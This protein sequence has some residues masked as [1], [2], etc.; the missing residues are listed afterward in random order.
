MPQGLLETFFI[1][2][3]CDLDIRIFKSSPGNS[4]MQLRLRTLVNIASEN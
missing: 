3:R 1:S 4:E 2:V